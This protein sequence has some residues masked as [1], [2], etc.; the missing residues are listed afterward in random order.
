[1]IYNKKDSKFIY[2]G[3]NM[4]MF[5]RHIHTPTFNGSNILGIIDIVLDMGSSSHWR[6]IIHVAPG[7]DADRDNVA[8]LFDLL[9]SNMFSVFIRIASMRRFQ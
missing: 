7:Q 5:I 6:L 9:W 4:Q 3:S 8:T 1:M 2:L